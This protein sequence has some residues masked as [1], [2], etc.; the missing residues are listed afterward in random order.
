MMIMLF[1]KMPLSLKMKIS[2]LHQ[3]IR[4]NIQ[5]DIYGK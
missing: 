3:D 2:I 4:N 1:N 5:V